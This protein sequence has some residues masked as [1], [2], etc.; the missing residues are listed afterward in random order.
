MNLRTRPLVINKFREYVGDKSVIIQ[1]KRLVEEMKVFIWKNG[2]AEA[3]SGY[4]DDLVM[5]F[6][7]AMYVRDTALKFK[8]QGVDLAR[9]M[10]SNIANTR[11]NFQGAYNPNTYN[12]PYQINYGHGAEDISWLL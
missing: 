5:S 11:P 10:L 9:A 2:K 8:S 7:T 6:G 3:Q 12:N 4:N 1:S